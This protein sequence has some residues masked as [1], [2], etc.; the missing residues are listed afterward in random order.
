MVYII[1]ICIAIPLLLLLKI[2]DKESIWLVGFMI[3]GMMAAVCS[4]EINSCLKFYTGF[5]SARVS[6]EI[7]PAVEEVLKALPILFYAILIDDRLKKIV[8]LAMAVGIG[9]ALL[10]NTYILVTNIEYVNYL[11]ALIR[12]LSTSL[13]H[14]MCT[15]IIGL[16]ISMVRKQK[17]LFYTGTFA[18]IVFSI[19]FHSIFNM[20]IMSEYSYFGMIMPVLLYVIY[21]KVFS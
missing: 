4:Y 16:G 6:I 12:G 20:L 15:L 9:F 3:L 1:F 7:A 14:G 13:N 18:L 17:K 21:V 11:W 19:C 10:E 8:S 2:I 5:N